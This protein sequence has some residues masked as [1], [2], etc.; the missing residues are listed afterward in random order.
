MKRYLS[1]AVFL[2]VC[3]VVALFIPTKNA[4]SETPGNYIPIGVSE[5]VSGTSNAWFIDSNTKRIIYCN[6]VIYDGPKSNI[7]CLSKNIP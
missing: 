3:A 4:V 6:G 1:A 7:H 5:G 2:F